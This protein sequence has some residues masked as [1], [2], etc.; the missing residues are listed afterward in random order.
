MGLNGGCQFIDGDFLINATG[1]ERGG[2]KGGKLKGPVIEGVVLKREAEGTGH[3]EGRAKRG[4]G[5]RGPDMEKGGPK[6]SVGQ[7]GCQKQKQY[8]LIQI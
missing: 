2:L 6:R 8:V 3:G 7:K 1:I 4:G 5:L